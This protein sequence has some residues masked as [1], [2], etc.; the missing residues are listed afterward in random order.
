[1]NNKYNDTYFIYMSGSDLISKIAMLGLCCL[2]LIQILRVPN[3]MAHIERS[4][5]NSQY[6]YWLGV[7]SRYLEVEYG[8]NDEIGYADKD[9]ITH[10]FLLPINTLLQPQKNSIYLRATINQWYQE[11][12]ALG[13]AGDL[14]RAPSAEIYLKFK[15]KETGEMTNQLLLDVKYDPS[16]DEYRYT[17]SEANVLKQVELLPQDDSLALLS[18]EPVQLKVAGAMVNFI[19]NDN[20]LPKLYVS[21]QTMEASEKLESEV[22]VEMGRILELFKA[23]SYESVLN[24]FAAPWRRNAVVYDYGNDARNY[25]DDVDMEDVVT[26]PDYQYFLDYSQSK[27]RLSANGKLVS[28]YPAVLKAREPDGFVSIE[29]TVIFMKDRDGNL[30]PGA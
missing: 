19:L 21:G 26:N 15:H 6:Y 9:S 17:S 25:A 11:Q 20:F 28:F 22:K 14:E 1:M 4:Y 24:Y 27:L 7:E 13:K 12:I 5:N 30:I 8:V 18:A 16:S 29:F 10:D 2:A 23:K 3:A